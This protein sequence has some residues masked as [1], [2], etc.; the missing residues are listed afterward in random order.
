MTQLDLV[1]LYRR[2]FFLL[3]AE[4]WQQ[5]AL[6]T[7]TKTEKALETRRAEFRMPPINRSGDVKAQKSCTNL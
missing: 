6:S 5:A 3:D 2:P 7:P 4:R 1:D